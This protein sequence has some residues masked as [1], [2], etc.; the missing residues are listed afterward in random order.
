MANPQTELNPHDADPE[1]QLDPAAVDERERLVLVTGFGVRPTP[2][3]ASP[4]N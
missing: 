4:P 2:P 3:S 1:A